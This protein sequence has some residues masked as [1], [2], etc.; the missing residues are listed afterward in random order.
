MSNL[1]WIA[2]GLLALYLL[3]IVVALVSSIGN[4]DPQRGVAQGCLLV[5]AF[6]LL[7]V[8]GVLALAV[9]FELRP[10]VYFVFALTM[11]PFISLVGGSAYYLVQKLR[12][13]E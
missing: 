6:G 1:V 3:G 4:N 12:G 10:L 9:R 8:A 2:A 13:I 5:V 11:F 7:G